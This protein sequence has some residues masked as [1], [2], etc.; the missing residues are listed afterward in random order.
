MTG[1]PL[2]CTI[3]AILVLL[4]AGAF[5]IYCAPEQ[6][7]AE[8]EIHD[9]DFSNGSFDPFDGYEEPELEERLRLLRQEHDFDDEGKSCTID[10]D[11]NAPLRCDGGTCEFP[12]A[13]TGQVDEETPYVRVFSEEEAYRFFVEI[14]DSEAER[15]RGL[16]FRQ[17]L[18]DDFGMLFVFDSE[19]FQSF[20]MRNTFVSLD[21]IFIDEGGEIVSISEDTEPLTDTSERSEAPAKYVL[22]VP[23]GTSDALGI[24]AGDHVEFYLINR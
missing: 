17:L 5:S 13:L 2:R 18:T 19:S 24:D 7:E 8:D 1:N 12:A 20:W 22:E 9:S 15:S 10:E 4:S 3:S 16:M 21:I 6:T 11:C 23:A 14:A